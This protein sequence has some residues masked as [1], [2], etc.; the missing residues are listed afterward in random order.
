MTELKKK[1]AEKYELV[2]KSGYSFK[3]A[4]FKLFKAV[5]DTEKKPEEWRKTTIM[6]IPKGK[7]MNGNLNH[8][9]HLHLKE[10]V[11][12][13]FVHII[14][15]QVKEKMMQ[16][17]TKYQLGTKKGHQPQEHIFVIKS[18]M[19]INQKYNQV[20]IINLYDIS[21]FFDGE[22]LLDVLGE[23]YPAGLK[24][25]VYRLMHEMNKNTIIKV[26]TAVGETEEE[27]I[28]AGLGQGGPESAIL[29][30]LSL[31]KGVQQYFADSP[32]MYYGNIPIK[33]TLWQDDILKASANLTEAQDCNYRMEAVLDSKYLKFNLLK[34][35]FIVFGDNKFKS[36]I[37]EELKVSPLLLKNEKMKQVDKYPYLGKILSDKNV[38]HSVLLT[39]NKRYGIA[40]KAI[41]EIKVVMEDTRSQIP[42]SFNTAIKMWEMAVLPALLNFSGCWIDIPRA[43]IEKLNKLQATFYRAILN[44]PKTCPT[45]GLFWFTGGTL[46]INKIIQNKFK[47]V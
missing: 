14:M 12:K 11:A 34:S 29:S 9:R 33:S 32:N 2:L 43:A 44:T 10:P 40:F 27:E 20:M 22:N 6:Q 28:D 1:K 45:P 5:W 16:N 8:M 38:G 25:K 37:E 47:R 36:K 46:M 23:A 7:Q 18:L 19:E 13:I 30:A 31:D 42:G 3:K 35:V 21:K 39:I 24:G 4:L 15:N 41:H 17:M 26:R